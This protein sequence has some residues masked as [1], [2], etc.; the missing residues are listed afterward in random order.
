MIL[1]AIRKWP[2]EGWAR[3]DVTLIK[4]QSEQKKGENVTLIDEKQEKEKNVERVN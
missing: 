1:A 2:P 3:V 4:Q